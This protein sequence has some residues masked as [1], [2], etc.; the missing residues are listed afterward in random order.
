M[1]T[2]DKTDRGNRKAEL[3]TDRLLGAGE[4]E[5]SKKSRKISRLGG[6]KHG[7]AI[8]KNR[9]HRRWYRAILHTLRCGDASFSTYN[10]NQLYLE[11]P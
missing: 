5:G 4:G 6:R 2:E 1:G 8:T 11:N 3:T 9:Q 10:M 7:D